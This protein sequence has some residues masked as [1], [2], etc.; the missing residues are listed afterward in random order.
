MTDI[1]D[2]KEPILYIQRYIYPQR[3]YQ[4]IRKKWDED[5]EGKF[6]PNPDYKDKFWHVNF[7]LTQ[8]YC[9]DDEDTEIFA[10][11]Y[12]DEENPPVDTDSQ[13]ENS[14]H[15]EPCLFIVYD[16]EDMSYLCEPTS[17]YGEDIA[18][19]DPH[20]ERAFE[21]IKVSTLREAID[22]SIALLGRLIEHGLHPRGILK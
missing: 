6:E 9:S 19:F 7:L 21:E 12:R 22:Q 4:V 14:D 3:V 17:N 13:E 2:D 15:V 5:T 8:E 18:E 20:D 1:S 11:V 10:L 16:A